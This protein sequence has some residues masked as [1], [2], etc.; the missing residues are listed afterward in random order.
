MLKMYKVP[1]PSDGEGVNG[2]HLVPPYR[3]ETYQ[4]GRTESDAMFYPPKT[5]G[6]THLYDGAPTPSVSGFQLRDRALLNREVPLVSANGKGRS[7]NS[8]TLVGAE[9]PDGRVS[10]YHAVVQ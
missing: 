7:A 5:M 8:S 4:Q 10:S 3:P 1:P 2:G 9:R 6:S